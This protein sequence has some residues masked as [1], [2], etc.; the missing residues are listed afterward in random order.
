MEK[1]NY[2]LFFKFFIQV[3]FFNSF[4]GYLTLLSTYIRLLTLF[5]FFQ[6]NS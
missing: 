3:P 5:G 6:L 2:S 4:L 1:Q